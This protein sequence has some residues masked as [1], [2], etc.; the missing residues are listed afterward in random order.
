LLGKGSMYRQVV[1]TSIF[2][3][4]SKNK[5]VSNDAER[6]VSTGNP[7]ASEN[8]ISEKIIERILVFYNDKTFREYRP[9]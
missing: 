9:E 3:T 6:N 7:K 5:S 1:Q 2:D 4:L 8:S